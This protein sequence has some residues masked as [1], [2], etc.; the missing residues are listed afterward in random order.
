M[1]W[2]ELHA[3]ALAAQDSA[4]GYY[5]RNSGLTTPD[6]K[7]NVR[8][9]LTAADVMDVRLW[10]EEDVLSAIRPYVDFA[11]ELRHVSQTPRFQV[12]SFIEGR[13]L[14]GFSPR[15][16]VVPDH[17]LNDVVT[18]MAQL[19]AIPEAKIPPLPDDWPVSGDSTAFGHRMAALTHRVHTEHRA[20]YAGVFEAFGFPADPLTAV[21][22]Q[23]ADLHPRP[24]V[25]LH[26][27]LHR[28]NMIVAGRATWF[29][30]WELA[31]WGDPSY[32]MAVHLH[33][34]DYPT[35]QRDGLLRR[36]LRTLPSECTRG[37]RRA[38]DTYL[39]HERIKSAIVD[40]IR[41]SKQLASPDTG[42]A[43]HDFLITRLAK[44][45]NAARLVWGL[46]PDVTPQQVRAGL[47][48]GPTHT[49]Q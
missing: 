26:A 23:W 12:Q 14:D 44:K 35:D 3:A 16:S 18:V 47:R 48:E 43:T 37:W 29:L 15:G 27:D 9:P 38:V 11:P 4:A 32:E 13:L 46:V 34:M 31:L 21:S 17:V 24:F 33:K 20:E 30:D 1:N 45:V 42:P 39:Q 40:T 49:S 22:G 19:A 2:L 10:R 5:N 25:V 28:K 6:G 41:Y 8:I 36:W 7:V